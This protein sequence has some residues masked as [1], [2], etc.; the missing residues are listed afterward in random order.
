MTPELRSHMEE[1]P[2][3]NERKKKKYNIYRSQAAHL[4]ERCVSFYIFGK[5]YQRTL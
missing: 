4:R 3:G 2:A 5:I 1:Y